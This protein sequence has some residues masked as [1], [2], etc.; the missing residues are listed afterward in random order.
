MWGL[1]PR[2]YHLA[3]VGVHALNTAPLYAPV[4][5]LLVRAVPNL[6]ASD[7]IGL[8]AASALAVARF[9]VHPLRTEVVAWVSCQPYLPCACV[10]MLAVLAYT[11][12]PEEDARPA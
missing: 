10:L 12:F 3:S 9:A 4:L 2:G 6:A 5:A 8:H 11:A 1:N 7:C